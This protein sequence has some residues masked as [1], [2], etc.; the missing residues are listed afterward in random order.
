MPSYT[1]KEL[2]S[3]LN[4]KVAS[5]V[6]ETQRFFTARGLTWADFGAKMDGMTKMGFKQALF[7]DLRDIVK[8]E[9]ALGATILTTKTEHE[10]RLVNDP[11]RL[12]MIYRASLENM[13]IKEYHDA[14]WES[15]GALRQAKMFWFY[16]IGWRMKMRYYVACAIGELK[17]IF[18]IK[19]E[20]RLYPII[21]IEK[22]FVPQHGFI[23]NQK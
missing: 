3:A 9:L 14:R 18:N 23:R 21:C 13:I 19:H 16:C 15:R 1:E 8:M 12:E 4:R 2:M 11:E 20:P 6:N 5:V 22:G 10:E 7:A 17:G